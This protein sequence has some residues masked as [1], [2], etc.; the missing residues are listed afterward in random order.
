M[1]QKGKVIIISGPSG[2]GKGAINIELAKDESLNLK[3]SVSATTRKPRVGEVEGVNYFFMNDKTFKEKI[4]KKEFIEHAKFIGN[5]YGT[6]RDYVKSQIDQGKNV[7]LEIEVLGATQV[8]KQEK[9]FEIVSIFLVPPSLTELEKR[10]RKRGTESE[11]I[12]KERLNKALLEIPLKDQYSY[13]IEND[14][15]S[16]VIAKIHDVLLYEDA[17]AT[18]TSEDS[19]RYVLEQE[20]MSYVNDKY[21]FFIEGWKSNLKMNKIK[22]DEAVIEEYLFKFIA[23]KI[24]AYILKTEKLSTIKSKEYVDSMIE[25][26]MLEVN[27]FEAIKKK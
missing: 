3:Y 14:E 25:Y 13:V 9:E 11:E 2:V 16:D 27:F 4:K 21:S 17:I 24:Y 20:V 15:I 8:L 26:Y 7:V 5:Y 6:P 19:Y 23:D 10:L 1:A 12:I 18:G 22:F